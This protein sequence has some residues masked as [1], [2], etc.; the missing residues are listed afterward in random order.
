[1]MRTRATRLHITKDY[2]GFCLTHKA[3]KANNMASLMAYVQHLLDL[4]LS[5]RTINNYISALRKNLERLGL[6]TSCFEHRMLEA[7]C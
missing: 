1:M 4:G 7:V 3:R 5:F 6:D 2:M